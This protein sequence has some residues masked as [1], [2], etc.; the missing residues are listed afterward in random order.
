ME[1]HQWALSGHRTAGSPRGAGPGF[2][3][4]CLGVSVKTCLRAQ[5]SRTR[6]ACMHGGTRELSQLMCW[7]RPSGSA[8]GASASAHGGTGVCQE[9]G[10]VRACGGA[11]HTGCRV[12]AGR[13]RRPTPLPPPRPQWAF[14]SPCTAVLQHVSLRWKG[15]PVPAPGVAYGSPK[16]ESP[17]LPQGPGRGA[18][19]RPAF[20][21]PWHGQFR[22]DVIHLRT[23]PWRGAPR[24][25]CSQAALGDPSQLL[26]GVCGQHTGPLP[27]SPI[28]GNFQWKTKFLPWGGGGAASSFLP[29]PDT[30]WVPPTA[31][32]AFACKD[33]GRFVGGLGRVTGG[34]NPTHLFVPS[35]SSPHPRSE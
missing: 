21:G 3:E 6:P 25:H 29:V 16:E 15:H 19:P 2:L 5:A 4:A 31:S 7:P 1:T 35:S 33:T 20:P 11:C 22:P 24:R 8:G 13:Q 27:S 9:A 17:W 32:K 30:Q 10:P 14:F 23:L 18:Q 34:G 28:S 26:R 12:D